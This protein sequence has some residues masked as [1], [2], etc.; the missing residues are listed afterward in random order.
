KLSGVGQPGS[1]S[2]SPP[3]NSATISGGALCGIFGTT[4][5]FTAT[6]LSALYPTHLAFVTKWDAATAAE[7]KRGYL[8]PVDARTLDRVTLQSNIG[9]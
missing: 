8:L 5:P 7:V 1:S 3:G 6:Q 2:A 9:G 4:V